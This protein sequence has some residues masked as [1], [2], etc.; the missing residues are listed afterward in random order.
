MCDG[1]WE[2]STAF[3]F[4]VE[5]V[6]GSFSVTCVCLMSAV[7]CSSLGRRCALCIVSESLIWSGALF[8]SQK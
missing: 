4:L 3:E 2:W 8:A 5:L 6:P 7:S 1:C